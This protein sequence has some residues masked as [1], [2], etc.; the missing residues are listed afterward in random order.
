MLD[1]LAEDALLQTDVPDVDP[2]ERIRRLLHQDLLK[3]P[4]RVV[5]VLVQHLRPP[6][7][8]FGLRLSG[9]ELQR[10]LQRLDRAGIVPER[11]QA[12]PLFDEGRGADVVGVHYRARAGE[13]RRRRLR[14]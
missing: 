5:V 8:G 11:D 4:E 10:F 9:G 13:L 6:E 1:R 12:P 2:G 3:G 7:E 14:R